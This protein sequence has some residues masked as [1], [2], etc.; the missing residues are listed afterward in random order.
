M[1]CR[2]DCLGGAPIGQKHSMCSQSNIVLVTVPGDLDVTTVAPVRRQIDSAIARGSRRVILN[3]A[4]ADYV[5]SAGMALIMRELRR[6]R[7]VGGLLSLIDVSPQAYKALVLMRLVDLMPVSAAG[8]RRE[9]SELAPWVLPLWQN[10]LAVD[11][12]RL[13]EARARV[14]QLLR[15]TALSADDVFDTT[16]AVG[17]ALGSAIDHTCAVG[18]LATVTA[19]PDRA[20]VDVSDCGEGFSLADGEEPP[21]VGDHAERGRGIRL[22]RMLVDA[23]SI[24]QK[25]S[26]HGTEVR[27]TKLIP[28]QD[29]AQ[30]NPEGA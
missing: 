9:V 23:V 21:A 4:A 27:L 12:D 29:A 24:T 13:A 22:M 10:T 28:R 2:H 5:D 6:L 1:T 17:E 19:Y 11:P 20:V 15:R 26:G 16:L 8:A 25:T 18:V 3:M 14:E 30:T 7:E